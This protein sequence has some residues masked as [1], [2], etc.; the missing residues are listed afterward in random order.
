MKP[1]N[2]IEMIEIWFSGCLIAIIQGSLKML[3]D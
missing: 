1:S 2:L 3:N